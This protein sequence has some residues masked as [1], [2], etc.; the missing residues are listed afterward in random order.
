MVATGV[1]VG[2]DV[3][4]RVGAG[5]DVTKTDVKKSGGTVLK[6]SKGVL[7][8]KTGETVGAGLVKARCVRIAAGSIGVHVA[9]TSIVGGILS[10][11]R[12]AKA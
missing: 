8:A 5:V 3:I 9:V 11:W 10:D 7:L 2:T 12:G 1:L 6:L 4:K